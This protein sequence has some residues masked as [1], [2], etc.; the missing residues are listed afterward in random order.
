[1]NDATAILI[2]I[3]VCVV[4]PVSIIWIVYRFLIN[5]TNKKT[6]IILE[7]IKNNPGID[8]EKLVESLKSEEITPWESLNRKLLR[9]SI[10][11]L[12]GIAFVL[13]AIFCPDDDAAEMWVVAGISGAIGIGFLI[14]YFFAYKHIDKLVAEKER[15]HLK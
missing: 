8:T 13:I 5:K 9:G 4:L 14:T 2:P 15:F 10:F 3:F 12:I 11:T 7:A 1:M 6:E